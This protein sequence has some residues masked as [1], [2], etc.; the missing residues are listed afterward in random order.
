METDVVDLIVTSIPFGNHYEYT[1]S[2]NDFGHTDDNEHFWAQ[3]DFLTPAA[4][5]GAE[6]RP[7]LRLPRQGPDQL[8]QRHRRRHP[9]PS[10]PFHAEAIFHGIEA[11]ASTTWG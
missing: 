9:A 5:P 1:P 11:T 2:Y 4:A 10:R 8:R 6:A 3:M 7:G